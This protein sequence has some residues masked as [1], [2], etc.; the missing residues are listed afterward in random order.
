MGRRRVCREVL[1]GAVAGA[2]GATALNALTYLDMAIRGRPASEVPEQVA[3]IIADRLNFGLGGDEHAR[4]REQ[5]I[6]PMLGVLTGVGVGAAY[7]ALRCAVRKVNIPIAAAGVGVAASVVSNLPMALLRVS[8]PRTWG[9]S[10]W[11]DDLIPHFGYGLAT[12]AAYE[13][14]RTSPDRR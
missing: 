9:V 12:V 1:A 10:G 3:D 8:D 4:N 13:M 2:A 14:M 11:V 6:G 7:G 5:G